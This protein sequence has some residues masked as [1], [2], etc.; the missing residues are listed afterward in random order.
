MVHRVINQNLPQTK[1]P[2][3]EPIVIAYYNTDEQPRSRKRQLVF[4]S[5][6]PERLIEL[7]KEEGVNAKL[8]LFGAEYTGG[9]APIIVQGSKKKALTILREKGL[10]ENIVLD[11][12][13]DAASGLG[14]DSKGALAGR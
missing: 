1:T 3:E 6:Q 4:G 8:N 9:I 11:I 5:A 7:F 2:T 10:N 12:A 13:L 14:K